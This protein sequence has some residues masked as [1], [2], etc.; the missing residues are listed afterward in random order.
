MCSDFNM[1]ISNNGVV[2]EVHI[3][4]KILPIKYKIISEKY[5]DHSGER[6]TCMPIL[7]A[8]NSSS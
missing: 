7:E 4:V 5:D 8:N 2:L 1:P 3:Q 6:I